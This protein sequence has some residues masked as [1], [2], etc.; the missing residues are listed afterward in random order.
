MGHIPKVT[1]WYTAE[2]LMEIR[3]HGARC[4]VLHR[5]LILI[6]AHSPE[7]AYAKATR[8]GQKGSKRGDSV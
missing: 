7:E 8:N 2:L 3:V 5:D 4:N 6:N 1:E